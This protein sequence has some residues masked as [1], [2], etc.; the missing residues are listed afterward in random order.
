MG[1][2]TALPSADH[3]DP[4]PS[5]I[6]RQRSAIHNS[7]MMRSYIDASAIDPQNYCSHASWSRP[8]A[9]AAYVLCRRLVPKQG[10]YLHLRF[11][12]RRQDPP[13]KEPTPTSQNLAI[14]D[15]YQQQFENPESTRSVLL[16]LLRP[17][18]CGV[19]ACRLRLRSW[20]WC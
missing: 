5:H 4:R 7:G 6:Y 16:L 3:V 14:F 9:W 8:N 10:H 13:R 15:H 12:T 20:P 2:S 18:C 11:V 1:A 19:D 17:A